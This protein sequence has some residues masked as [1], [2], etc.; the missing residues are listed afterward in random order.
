LSLVL[1]VSHLQLVSNVRS[2]AYDGPLDLLLF[3]VRRQ[4]VDLREI[5]IAPIADAFVAQLDHI[6]AFDLDSASDFVVMAST[7]CW[8]K[9][10]EV[11]V[12]RSSDDLDDEAQAVRAD[13]SRR[14]FEFQRYRDA[15]QQL[16]A[17]PQLGR[18]TFARNPE[19][20][21][22]Y[23]RPVYA[24]DD[25]FGLL[26]RFYAMLQKSAAPAP[27]HTVTREPWTME[28]A[29][30]ILLD[31][32]ADGPRDLLDILQQLR[33]RHQK[34]FLV[35]AVLELA[36]TGTLSLAQD[37]HLGSIRLGLLQS[38]EAVDLGHL[39]GVVA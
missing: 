15:A 6:E 1:P 23:E 5:P 33:W 22:G 14:L 2:P 35:L 11:L 37:E 18:D 4:G 25:A 16:A 28:D 12:G 34:V 13:L 3:L 7:L 38:R 24:E 10:R 19:P 30:A 17:A 27:V 36:K 20:V 39:E 9:S 8:L 32:L 21:N 26:E 29:G 31:A